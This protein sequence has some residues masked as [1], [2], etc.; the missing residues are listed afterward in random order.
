VSNPNTEA[1]RRWTPA[2]SRRRPVR[3]TGW[4]Q[5]GFVQAGAGPRRLVAGPAVE[6]NGLEQAESAGWLGCSLGT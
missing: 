5:M 4:A 2:E 1:W 6:A 3:T